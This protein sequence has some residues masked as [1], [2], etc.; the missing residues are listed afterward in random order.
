ML[1]CT[2]D[3]YE[4][5][6]NHIRLTDRQKYIVEQRFGPKKRYYYQVAMDLCLSEDMIKVESRHIFDKVSRYLD[7]INSA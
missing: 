7:T 2:K 1:N 6:F 5:L 4:N 3:E